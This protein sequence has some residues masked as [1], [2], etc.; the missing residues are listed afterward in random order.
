MTE[1]EKARLFR[2][3]IVEGI[4]LYHEALHRPRG[5]DAPPPAPPPA[6]VS[7][8]PGRVPPQGTPEAVGPVEDE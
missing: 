3:G 7:E 8:P 5:Q 2:E 6:V 1:N 4:R